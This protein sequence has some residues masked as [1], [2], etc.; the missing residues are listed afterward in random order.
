MSISSS[1]FAKFEAD[2]RDQPDPAESLKA[3]LIGAGTIFETPFGPKPLIYADYVASGRALRQ[4]EDFMLAQVLP[5]YANS[6]TEASFTGAQTTALRETARAE[7]AKRCGADADTHAVIFAGSGATA[8]L[9]KL[10]HLFAIGEK[11]TCG[12]AVTVLVG[13]Y[14]HHSNLL[15]WRE[16]GA[17]VIELAEAPA[18]GVDL[19]DLNAKLQ[20]ATAKGPT[21]AAISAASN[22]T[23]ICA[24]V[25]AVTKAVKQ[26]GAKMVWDFAGGGPYLPVSMAHG[27]DAIALSPHKFIGGPGASGVLIL[28]RDAVCTTK[29][30]QPGGGTVAFVNAYQHDYSVHLEDRE[31]GGTPNILGDI[32]AALALIV[33]DVIGQ[34]KLTSRNAD[35]SKRAFEVLATAPGLKVLGSDHQTRLPIIS[36]IVQGAEYDYNAFTTALS[37]RFGI[38]VRGGCSCAGPYVH[39][40]LNIDDGWSNRL[41]TEILSGDIAHKPGFVRFNLSVLMP[42]DEVDYILS[43]VAELAN[44]FAKPQA[45]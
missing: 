32:R 43:S 35:L 10:V 29:P 28:R 45:A 44:E 4:I 2:L 31:E 3:G 7:I 17:E 9:N 22:V 38:Q 8:G 12:E 18:G 15:P 21:I 40:L 20:S 24:D 6:H 26:A 13:P 42:Q 39:R 5:F 33:K 23:G 1:P 37:D 14:E 27:I 19:A 36:F 30:S 16:S 25:K 34:D 41:R 11:L